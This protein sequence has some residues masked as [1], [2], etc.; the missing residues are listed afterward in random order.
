MRAR[1]FV[2]VL[3]R[4]ADLRRAV[5]ECCA[6]SPTGRAS[7]S[8]WSARVLN[9]RTSLWIFWNSSKPRMFG[10]ADFWVVPFAGK[11]RRICRR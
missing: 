3:V 4:L 7:G 9:F 2:L 6:A 1:G 5:L 8:D 11:F 10:S